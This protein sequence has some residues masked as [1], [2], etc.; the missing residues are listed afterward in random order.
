MNTIGERIKHQRK[1]LGL[2]QV[3]LAKMVGVSNVSIRNWEIGESKQI[4]YDNMIALAKA[5]HTTTDW[6]QTGLSLGGGSRTNYVPVL[7]PYQLAAYT[8]VEPKKYEKI[9]PDDEI[10]CPVHHSDKTFA[11]KLTDESMLPQFWPGG[12]VFCDPEAV[13]SVADFVLAVTPDKYSKL[14]FRQYIEPGEPALLKALNDLWP[15]KYMEWRA[16]NLFKVIAYL[17]IL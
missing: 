9:I 12:Y 3:D 11:V 1:Q 7:Q 4:R 17:K 13:V 10:P 16:E 6:L 14:A 2:T 8:G 5:L 15:K